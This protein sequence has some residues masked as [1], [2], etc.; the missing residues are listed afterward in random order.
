MRFCERC[1]SYME[2]TTKG[3]V[4]PKC[5]NEVFQDV[6]EI[7]R[8]EK[9]SAEPVY[10]VE[11]IVDGS[12]KVAQKCPNCGYGE[13]FRIVLTTQGEHAGV[14]Q[15]RSVERFT[16]AKCHHTWTRS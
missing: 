6:I 11:N 16:C 9:P 13:A 3:L 8:V 2:R 15:D 10:V 5:G 1:G 4:C 14:K 12:L 7:R